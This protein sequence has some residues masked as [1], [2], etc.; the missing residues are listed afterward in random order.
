LGDWL[1]GYLLLT[2]GLSVFAIAPLFYPGYFQTYTGFIPIWSINRLRENWADLSW[3]PALVTFNPW[4]SDGLLPYYL[5]AFLPL[6]ALDALKLVAA[7][8]ILAGSSGLYLWLRSWLGAQGASIAALVYTYAPFMIAALYARG[9]WGE[10]FFWGI[11]PWGLLSATGRTWAGRS[12]RYASREKPGFLKK[13]GFCNPLRDKWLLL[14]A[15]AI[16][17]I[18][19][20]LSQLGLSVWAYLL[21][22]AMLFIFHRRQMLWPVA[23]AGAG[24]LAAMLITFPRLIHELEPSPFDFSQHLVYPSQLLSSFWGY[25]FSRPGWDDG[26]S[27]SLGLAGLGLTILTFSIWRGGPERRPWFFVG[28]AAVSVALSLSLGGW[29]WRAPG[30]N[31]LLTY[32]WQL[33]GFA[34]L[35]L[36]VLAGVG[37]W[38]DERL[39][40]LPLFGAAVLFVLLPMYPN[41]KAHY[42]PLPLPDAPEAIYGQ[43]EILLLSHAFMVANPKAAAEPNA[44]EPY[45]PVTAETFFRMGSA[46]YLQ[47]H[48]QALKPLAQDYKVF[49]HL[50]DEQGQLI[51]QVDV[52]PQ[53]GGRPTSTWQPGELIEDTYTFKLPYTPSKPAQV[54]LGFY[55]GETLMRL[56]ALGDDE[57]RA[58][59]NVR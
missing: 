25:G 45:L 54:W 5:A 8:G 17:W 47:V 19:L 39:Q 48:W 57:G 3:L 1:D 31:H 13:P 18:G 9:A 32:P 20:G 52:T 2:L 14:A 56:P 10:A 42:I 28:A 49:A 29:V 12:D 16:G 44:A 30:L 41:L 55:G 26:L 38:L 37:F 21:L 22:L 24:L 43:N 35:G 59:L 50:V 58:F 40:A 34:T 11:L 36:S 15:G 4:R 23:A 51:T 7:A 27:F 53:N 46:I 6:N 33:L